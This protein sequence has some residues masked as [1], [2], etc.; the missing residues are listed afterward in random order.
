MATSLFSVTKHGSA[1]FK[2][3]SPSDTMLPDFCS[4]LSA[5]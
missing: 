4:S 5:A 1:P 3:M 2:N